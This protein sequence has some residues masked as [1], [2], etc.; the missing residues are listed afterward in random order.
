[1]KSTVLVLAALLWCCATQ[2]S[3]A[4]QRKFGLGVIIGEPTGLSAKLWTSSVNAFDFGLG[5]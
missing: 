4:Q 3:L 1:M 5:W 2:D